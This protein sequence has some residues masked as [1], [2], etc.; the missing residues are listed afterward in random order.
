MG[1]VTIEKIVKSSGF[2][3]MVF[4]MSVVIYVD[5]FQSRNL[6]IKSLGLQGEV[7]VENIYLRFSSM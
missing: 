5:R 7:W 6:H 4:R 3:H 1:R 2:I